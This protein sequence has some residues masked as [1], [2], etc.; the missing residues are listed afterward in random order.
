MVK[1]V[2]LLNSGFSSGVPS[3]ILEYLDKYNTIINKAHT[4][5]VPMYNHVH[6]NVIHARHFTISSF[7]A[8]G[9][10]THH[11]TKPQ[12]MRAESKVTTG[13]NRT[14]QHEIL[15]RSQRHF[16]DALSLMS[17]LLPLLTFQV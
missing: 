3:F 11:A 15:K 7:A 16:F 6:F 12:M 2:A 8:F 10:I 13:L 1:Y 4:S 5:C 14:R 9:L 17:I